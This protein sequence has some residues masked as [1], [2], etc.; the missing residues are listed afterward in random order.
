VCV[1]YDEGNDKLRDFINKSKLGEWVYKPWL[2]GIMP[3]LQ[4]IGY[5]CMDVNH[6]H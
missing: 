4:T 6:G 2:F 1:A 3:S 5:V